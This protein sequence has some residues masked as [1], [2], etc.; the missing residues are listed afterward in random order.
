MRIRLRCSDPEC[1]REYDLH[2][3]SGRAAG[4]CPRCGREQVIDTAAAVRDDVLVRCPCCGSEELYVRKDF[5]QRLGLGLVVV[6]ALGSFYFFGR[7][8]LGWALGILVGL[9]VVDLIIYR[10]VPTITV[11]YRC[12]AEFR[13]M[14]INPAHKGFDLATAEKYRSA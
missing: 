2:I 11:C 8:E 10:L 1:G 12:K 4:R 3:D 6:V 14:A 9:V 13:D 7:G 5:P